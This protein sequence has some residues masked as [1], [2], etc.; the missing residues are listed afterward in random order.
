MCVAPQLQPLQ[1]MLL[2]RS[3]HIYPKELARDMRE[4][5]NSLLSAAVAH[6]EQVADP[7][8]HPIERETRT[9]GFARGVLSNE[10]PYRDSGIEEGGARIS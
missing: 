9:P 2:R 8:S 4:F 1:G 3:T 6:R 7:G 10:Q 5:F